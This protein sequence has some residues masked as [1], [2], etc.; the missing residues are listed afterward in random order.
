MITNT[1]KVIYSNLFSASRDNI[2]SLIENTSNVKDPISS[3][4]QSR[5]WIYSRI[6]DTK[7][8]DFKGYP[9]IV[10]YPSQFEPVDG[11]SLNGKSKFV[12]WEIEIEL[13]TSDRGYGSEDG[14]GL[15]HIDSLTNDIFKTLMDISNRSILSN[16]NLKFSIPVS[17]SVN[18]DVLAEELV[19]RRSIIVTLKNRIQV[20]A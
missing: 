14:K 10:V 3:S 19:Y 7:S 20:S 6:P 18:T 11:G 8:A 5:K 9:L 2:V 15:I 12:S 17:T 4:G 1:E 16:N 13:F